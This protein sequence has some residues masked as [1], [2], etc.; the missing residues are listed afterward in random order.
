ML[1]ECIVAIIRCCANDVDWHTNPSGTAV[2]YRP[3]GLDDGGTGLAAVCR[4]VEQFQCRFPA[5]L[6]TPSCA[7]RSVYMFCDNLFLQW[8]LVLTNSQYLLFQD[9]Y[10]SSHWQGWGKDSNALC[11]SADIL[12][13]NEYLCF[14]D[15]PGE[16]NATSQ[17]WTGVVCTAN[18]TVLCISLP[19]W[20]LT[21]NVNALEE[22]APL[23]DM[24]LVNLAN[25]SLTG[26]HCNHLGC[27]LSHMLVR[28][29]I[30][31]CRFFA[32]SFASSVQ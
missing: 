24:Q 5:Q 23:Q 6:D 19:S 16:I 7:S 2:P 3:V 13:D 26:K 14:P 27:F 22:L 11:P 4:A 29:F 25:N 31:H 32:G 18:G 30:E 15:Y 28:S 9:T 12:T 1:L 20:G 21:G 17:S 10:S 8:E